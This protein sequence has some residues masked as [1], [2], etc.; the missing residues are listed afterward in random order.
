MI[1]K[2]I[3]YT[4]I[5]YFDYFFDRLTSICNLHSSEARTALCYSLQ[6][7]CQIQDQGLSHFLQHIYQ[8]LHWNYLFYLID[9]PIGFIRIYIIIHSFENLD[10]RLS[11]HQTFHEFHL[12]MSDFMIFID[13]NSC[14]NWIYIVYFTECKYLS[15]DL[16]FIFMANYFPILNN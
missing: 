15:L 5:D 2:I 11:H 12:V 10:M 6:N 3:I 9:C 14:W 16:L 13:L 8:I 1:G 7:Q 4:N